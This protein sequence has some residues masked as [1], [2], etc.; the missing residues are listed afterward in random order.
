MGFYFYESK[1][2]IAK[3]RIKTR[4]PADISANLSGGNIQK[5]TF[6]RAFM[7]KPKVIIAHSPTR[8]LD[9]PTTELAYRI[10][11][12]AKRQGVGILLISEDLDELLLLCD[13][14]GVMYKGELMGILKRGRYDR[15]EIGAMMAG[16]K[17]IEA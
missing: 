3:F 2:V 9:I 13:R 11:L 7:M 8:G 4:S 14:I 16:V 17:R 12:E 1:K 6:A 5:L 15:Y 10:M